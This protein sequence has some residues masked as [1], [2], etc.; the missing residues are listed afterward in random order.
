MCFVQ[1]A[2]MPW[3]CMTAERS[4]TVRSRAALLWIAL[5]TAQTPDWMATRAGHLQSAALRL[6]RMSTY[7]YD[8][9]FHELCECELCMQVHL[10]N[11]DA[12]FLTYYRCQTEKGHTC[13]L[14]LVT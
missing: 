5:Q 8:E 13:R 14:S 9:L 1:N 3:D 2:L 11:N 6:G 12:C 7:R 10:L 4:L